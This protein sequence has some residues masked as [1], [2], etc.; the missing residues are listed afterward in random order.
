VEYRK[1]WNCHNDRKQKD[2][3]P[4]NYKNYRLN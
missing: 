3:L 2:K 1:E 4:K